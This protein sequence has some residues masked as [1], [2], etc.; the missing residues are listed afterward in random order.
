MPREQRERS[1]GSRQPLRERE[2]YF[3][4]VWDADE[5]KFFFTYVIFSLF[6]ILYVI[7]SLWGCVCARGEAEAKA[8]RT[9]GGPHARIKDRHSV[10]WRVSARPCF[11]IERKACGLES[12]DATRRRGSKYWYIVRTCT[13]K[14]RRGEIDIHD[15]NGGSSASKNSGSSASADFHLM[16]LKTTA[17]KPSDSDNDIIHQCSSIIHSERRKA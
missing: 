11:R 9:P 7:F 16:N 2:T 3:A 15:K 13:L 1:R 4:S 5:D 14:P 6:G 12:R 10:Q 8:A 17:V